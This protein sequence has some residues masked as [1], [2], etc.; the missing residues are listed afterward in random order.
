MHLSMNN[1]GEYGRILIIL[2][3]YLF[4]AGFEQILLKQKINPQCNV[5]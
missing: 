1:V 3:Q 4:P 2:R 5:S